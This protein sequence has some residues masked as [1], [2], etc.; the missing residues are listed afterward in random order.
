M[1][2][3]SRAE[4]DALVS[5]GQRVVAV[6]REVFADG[7]SPVSLYR[8]LTDSRPG[9]FLLESAEQG[10]IW[11]RFSFLGVESFGTLT[12]IA[13]ESHWINYSLDSDVAFG[14]PVPTLGLDAV[15]T[16]TQRWAG[17]RSTHIAPLTGGLVGFIGWDAVRQLE[18][19]PHIPPAEVPVPGHT[20]A[21]DERSRA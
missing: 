3:T 4:F 19:L 8:R 7:D 13:G 2:Q 11:S 1:S 16:L 9:S 15:S 5:S 10:G 12:D 18:R 17:S 14:G 21:R 20:H 6:S